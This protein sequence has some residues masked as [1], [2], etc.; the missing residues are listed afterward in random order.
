MVRIYDL[1]RH[2]LT[3]LLQV[4]FLCPGCRA[5]LCFILRWLTHQRS[6]NL[7]LVIDEEYSNSLELTA[8]AD[9]DNSIIHFIFKKT[10]KK[11]SRNF[12]DRQSAELKFESLKPACTGLRT[13]RSLW[14]RYR[15]IFRLFFNVRGAHFKTSLRYG[16]S[17]I[18]LSTLSISKSLAI[19][20]YRQIFFFLSLFR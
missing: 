13:K 16:S 20:L 19:I 9:V 6:T 18:S 1:T 17:I 8:H 11:N 12:P 15:I 14:A 10:V 3:D 7:M 4:P 2:L 5:S